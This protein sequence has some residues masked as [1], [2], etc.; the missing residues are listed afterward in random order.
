MQKKEAKATNVPLKKSTLA[1][2][3]V[4]TFKQYVFTVTVSRERAFRMRT[5]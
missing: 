3:N 5:N 1:Y 2:I 4:H